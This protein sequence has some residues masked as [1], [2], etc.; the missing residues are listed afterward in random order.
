MITANIYLALTK[1]QIQL[2][3]PLLYYLILFHRN[4]VSI[5]ITIIH[6]LQMKQRSNKPSEWGRTA[7]W[8][9]RQHAEPRKFFWLVCVLFCPQNREN[10]KFIHIQIC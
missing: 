10:L 7:G 8:L 3:E 6:I 9:Q 2:W 5:S 4:G 1:C